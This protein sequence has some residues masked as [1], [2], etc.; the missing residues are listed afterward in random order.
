M[1]DNSAP[2]AGTAA[3]SGSKP[4]DLAGYLEALT[5]PVFQAGISWRVVDSKWDAIRQGFAGFAPDVVAGYGP[6]EIDRLLDDPR[7]IR[8]KA[9]IQATIDNARAVLELDAEYG[10]FDRYLHSRGGFDETVADLKRQFRYIGDTGA[11]HFLWSV[12]E[13]TPPHGSW[14]EPRRRKALPGHPCGHNSAE[15]AARRRIST[16]AGVQFFITKPLNRLRTS[17]AAS[18]RA[19]P[20]GR[21]PAW[22]TLR[23]SRKPAT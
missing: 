18:R 21:S 8:S 1:D 6:R 22:I 14:P 20:A 2:L 15:R 17:P 12:G 4:G 10:G 9:K 3:A 16:S 7:V 23:K 5:R 11:Y 13:P 19:S